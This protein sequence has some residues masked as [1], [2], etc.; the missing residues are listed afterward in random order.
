MRIII[1]S[2]QVNFVPNFD[3]S[4]KEPLLLP[5]RLPTL[6]LNGAS[7]IAVISYDSFP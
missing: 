5:A 3:E 6:L 7:G 1:K 4:Q 2:L